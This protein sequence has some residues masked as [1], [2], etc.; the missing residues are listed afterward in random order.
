MLRRLSDIGVLADGNILSSLSICAF[1]LLC[2]MEEVS[3]LGNK[4]NLGLMNR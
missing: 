3:P 4:R 1:Y 2:D